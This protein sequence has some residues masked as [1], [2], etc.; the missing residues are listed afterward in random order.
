MKRIFHLVFILCFLIFSC[1]KNQNGPKDYSGTYDCLVYGSSFNIFDST[2]WGTSGPP[3][4]T[5]L[6]VIQNGSLITVD[7]DFTFHCDSV[8][9]ENLYTEYEGSS[10]YNTIRFYSNDSIY[11]KTYSGGLGGSSSSNYVGRKM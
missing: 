1:E 5:T 2:T 8:A 3:T 4:Q 10:S 6:D 7:N 11:Y 9:N